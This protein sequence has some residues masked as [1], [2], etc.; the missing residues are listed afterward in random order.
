MAGGKMNKPNDDS[1]A[2]TV[3]PVEIQIA[4]QNFA[5]FVKIN[6]QLVK[7]N[8]QLKSIKNILTI[9]EVIVIVGIV[10]SVIGTCGTIIR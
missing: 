5:Q 1:S 7:M 8:E 2:N 6:D 9:F 10:V 4:R 3:E